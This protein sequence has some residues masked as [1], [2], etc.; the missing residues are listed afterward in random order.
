[1][2]NHL[3]SASM[4]VA[5]LLAGSATVSAMESPAAAAKAEKSAKVNGREIVTVAPVIVES[6]EGTAPRLPYRVWTSYSDGKAEFRQVR[7]TNDARSEEEAEAARKAGSEY[8]VKGYIIGD[9]TT[10]DGYPVEAKVKVVKGGY[11]TPSAK[12]VANT[13]PLDQVHIEGDNRLTSNRDMA[14]EHLL[15]LDVTQQLY[16]YR[17]TYGLPT[18]GYTVSDGWDSPTTKLKGHGTGHYLSALAFAY[19]SATNPAQKAA[20]YKNIKRMIDEMRECQERTFVFDEKLGRYR[21]ARDYAPEEELRNMKGTWAAFDEHKKHYEEYGYGYM[22]AI[23]AAHPALIEMYRAYNNSDWVWAP[24]YTIHKQLAGLIDIATYMD[25]KALA[26]KAFLIAKDMGL[27]VWNRMHYRT[28]VNAEGDQ[29]VRRAKPGNRLE[30]WNMYIAGEVGGMEESLSRLAEMATDREEKEKLLEAANCFDAP[31]MFNALSNN[32][33]DIRT[34]HANQHIPMIVGALRSYISNENPYYY[35]LSLNFWNMIQGRY[36]YS[37]G[38]V[39]NGEMFRE[40]YTQILSMVTNGVSGNGGEANPTLNETCCAYNLAKLTKDLA[41]FDP[42]N[43]EYMD[44]YERV[45]YNQLV[46]SIDH[47]HFAVTYHYA[48]G[49]NASKPF[50]SETPGSTCCGGTGSENHVKYQEAAYF[51]N[52]NTL[53]VG[54]YM[55]NTLDWKANGIKVKESCAWPAENAKFT[56]EGSAKFTLKLR[57]PYWA[58]EGFQVLVN[59]KPVADSYQPSSYVVIP[60][61]TWSSSDVIEVTMPF[62]V[63]FDFGPDKLENALAADGSKLDAKWVGTLMY[64]PLAM[65]ATGVRNWEEATLNVD[66]QLAT[67]VANGHGAVTEGT[68][69]NLYTLTQGAFTFQPDYYRNENTTHYFRIN[70]VADPSEEF[71]AM[72]STKIAGLEVYNPKNYTKK[73][74]KALMKAC[75]PAVKLLSAAEVSQ[76][77]VAAAIDAISAAEN[78]LKAIKLDK[79]VLEDAVKAAKN[80]SGKDYTWDSWN[81][82]NTELATASHILSH[83]ENQPEIDRQVKAFSDA[84]AMLVPVSSV[85]RSKLQAVLD[86]AQQR[87]EAQ[88]K[89]NALEVKVPEFAPWANGGF[90]RLSYNVRYA[91]EVLN[92]VEKNYNQS[93]VD[94]M[95]AELNSVI[96]SMR[97]GNLAEIEDLSY[98]RALI[99]GAEGVAQTD[100]VKEAIA[101]ARM[102]YS[103]VED[104]SGTH[105]MIRNAE[106]RLKAVVGED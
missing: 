73:S 9:N 76:A 72:V 101:Y 17:D 11:K 18:E 100:E 49:L 106:N 61:R 84:S 78:A 59:G 25:D 3:V 24:Y 89:W 45:L 88:R 22:N 23:P 63:H 62:D 19:A 35:N 69:G 10:A 52:D 14:I 102:V 34:R 93:E 26:D 12:P 13:I 4:V 81:A 56:F 97:P 105:D 1:M 31:I 64:G 8:T 94:E 30:M 32:I 98:L 74:Y 7:W 67:V 15:E 96:S 53:W 41:C 20:L 68:T 38:G 104:G 103:Y 51:A 21:E 77:E 79:S 6:P 80:L 46:G 48:M 39:G 2:K 91:E 37:E 47:N 54:L 75:K 43:A 44:Y 95:T 90:R 40:P 50:G 71:K 57:V 99:R 66:S 5:A 86:I 70:W 33:D 85:D 27:W 82:F 87:I 36:R 58:T 28:H 55:P 29:E 42:D 65:T 83:S 16:N 92:N 60:E